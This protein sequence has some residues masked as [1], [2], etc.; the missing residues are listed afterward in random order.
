MH[1]RVVSFLSQ[2]WLH[3]HAWQGSY[4]I[5]VSHLPRDIVKY[6]TNLTGALMTEVYPDLRINPIHTSPYYPEADGML[7][8][9]H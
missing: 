4:S 5:G 2:K 8:R 9:F 6:G 7:E 3:G 1:T